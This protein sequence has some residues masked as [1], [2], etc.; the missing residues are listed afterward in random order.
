MRM[1]K[2][3]N[4]PVSSEN[5]LDRTTSMAAANL[6]AIVFALPL[7]GLMLPLFALLWSWSTLWQGLAS[8]LDVFVLFVVLLVVGIVIH[9]A[10]HSL[11]WQVFG[12]LPAGTVKFGVMWKVLTPY[13]HLTRPVPA[14][15][16]RAGTMLP[17]LVL[18]ILPLMIALLSGSGWLFWIGLIFTQA[19]GGDFF[20]LWLLRD[21]PAFWLV[22]DHPVRAGCRVYPPA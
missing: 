4:P 15:V 20:I 8:L 7:F 9:E 3:N 5:G 10:L 19:A 18:G 21:V 6:I 22:E 13:A 2:A 16:Y 14:R 12:K 1:P 11:G 17:G